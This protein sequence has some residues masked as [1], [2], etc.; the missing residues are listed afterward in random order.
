MRC[1]SSTGLL[2]R[3]SLLFFCKLV[4]DPVF[5]KFFISFCTSM[6]DTISVGMLGIFFKVCIYVTKT[7]PTLG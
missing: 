5:K 2:D 6:G 1:L 4:T 7:G 3:S